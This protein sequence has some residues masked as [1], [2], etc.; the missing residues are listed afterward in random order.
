MLTQ[1][2][3]LFLS[4]YSPFDIY[5][6]TGEYNLRL[7]T[8]LSR[9]GCDIHYVSLSEQIGRRKL[10]F[11]VDEL[12][13]Y[14]KSLRIAGWLQAGSTFFDPHWKRWLLTPLLLFNEATDQKLVAL[15]SK[16]L[17]QWN[18]RGK[19]IV[20][21]ERG[22]VRRHLTAARRELIQQAV[23]ELE[24]QVVIVDGTLFGDCF[25]LVPAGVLKIS[26]THDVYHQRAASLQQMGA[27]SAGSYV[28]REEEAALLGKADLVVALQSDEAAVLSGLA[29]RR[30]I[31][32]VP[33]APVALPSYGVCEVP[34]RCLFVGSYSDHNAIGLGWFLS[35]V[36]PEILSHCSQATLHI[37]G[38]VG[39]AFAGR[40][41]PSV[42]F[43]GLVPA[44]GVEYAAAQV[45]LVPLQAG[46]GLKIKTVQ[47]LAQGKPCVVTRFG[48]QGLRHLEGEALLVADS[49]SRFAEAVVEL[50]VNTERRE[51]LRK[52]A[53]YAI[54]NYFSADTCYRPLLDE[55]RRA[56]DLGV[57]AFLGSETR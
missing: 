48:I 46:S 5:M 22:S 15:C 34:G 6:G 28:T 30:K 37:C 54:H 47:A 25:D 23:K 31:I 51:Q 38:T 4:G 17:G 45:C 16:C 10:I 44:L 8:Y 42:S 39:R 1:T 50:L 14:I 3:V 27:P 35:E 36:W 29:P 57:G 24:P 43:R 33:M 53:R 49:P 19:F 55:M 9:H 11:S 20:E 7:L 52:G 56:V 12:P 13:G 40:S 41:F 26:V 21:S 2:R 18:R 32:T